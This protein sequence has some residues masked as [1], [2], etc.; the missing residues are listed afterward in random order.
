MFNRCKKSLKLHFSFKLILII[1]N[2]GHSVLYNFLGDKCG[3][4][5]QNDSYITQ[6]GFYFPATSS[7]QMY[8][9][10]WHRNLIIVTS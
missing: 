4:N 7:V 8:T 2:T 10:S 5:V 6:C 9:F 3:A 1:F